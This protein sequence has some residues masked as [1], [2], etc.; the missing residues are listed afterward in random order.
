MRHFITGQ[1]SGNVSPG[2]CERSPSQLEV[3]I[4]FDI[5]I[6]CIGSRTGFKYML[7]LTICYLNAFCVFDYFQIHS[8]KQV[9]LFEYLNG[10]L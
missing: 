2:S 7:Y 6:S 1:R 3:R 9:F 5:L 8:L 10:Y 4:K